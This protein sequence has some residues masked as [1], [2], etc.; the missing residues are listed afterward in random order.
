MLSNPVV[1]R[2]L[3]VGMIALLLSIAV[4]EFGHA[5]VA[6]RLGDRLPRNQGRVTLNP[7]VHADPIGTWALPIVGFVLFAMSGQPGQIGFGWGRPVQ[8]NPNS[9]T[10]KLRMRTAH[11]LVAAA[12]PGMNLIFG[13][14]VMLVTFACAKANLIHNAEVAQ[15][16][17]NLIILNYVLAF[18]N[19]VPVPPLD[20][21]TVLAGL[22]PRRHSH[23]MDTI[24]QYSFMLLAGIMFTPAKIIFLW[25]AHKVFEGLSGLIGFVPALQHSLWGHSA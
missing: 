22:L 13:T 4:H 18:F 8:V 11:L 24:G 5:Y 15:A 14:L 12:G 19:L 20:G 9:F 16:L 6:D 21:G 10:R 17:L 7:L 3:I 1:I 23:V 2:E 25:P